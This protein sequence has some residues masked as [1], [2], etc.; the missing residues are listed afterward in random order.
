MD[1]PQEPIT[2]SHE[3]LSL[4]DEFYEQNWDMISTEDYEKAKKDPKWLKVA[5]SIGF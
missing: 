2:E 4:L 1:K 3:C 5:V